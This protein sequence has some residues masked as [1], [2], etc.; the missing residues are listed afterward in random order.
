MSR[1]D[2]NVKPSFRG[3]GKKYA[4]MSTTRK[5]KQV[6]RIEDINEMMN[7]KNPFGMVNAVVKT[8]DKSRARQMIVAVAIK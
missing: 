8:K 1:Y 5:I 3:M 4:V 7:L 2:D 6:M